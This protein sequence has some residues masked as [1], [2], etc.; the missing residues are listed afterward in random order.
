[1]DQFHASFRGS[2]EERAE[3][4]RYYERFQGDMPK[5]GDA[6]HGCVV[7]ER[8]WCWLLTLES[9]RIGRTAARVPRL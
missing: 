6:A 9:G 4:L 3:L 5:A 1:M 7:W 2:P 8:V